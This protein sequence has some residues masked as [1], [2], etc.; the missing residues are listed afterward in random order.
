MA[1]YD[2][3]NPPTDQPVRAALLIPWGVIPLTF[4][5]RRE[6]RADAVVVQYGL[7]QKEPAMT[8]HSRCHD[9]RCF[10]FAAGPASACD[11]NREAQHHDPAVATTATPAE[12]MTS[13]AAATP[14]RRRRRFQRD[15]PQPSTN[16]RRSS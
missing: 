6:H 13:Q 8:K 12:Q 7:F 5:D 4:R 11:W 14:P 3:A 9:F 15:R 1:D 2:C 10:A 16:R